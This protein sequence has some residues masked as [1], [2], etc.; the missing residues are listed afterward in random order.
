MYMYSDENNHYIV[1]AKDISNKT[2]GDIICKLTNLTEKNK[3]L[4]L[5]FCEL[6]KDP[7]HFYRLNKD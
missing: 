7:P 2:I 1:I 6:K 5:Y 4:H 3:S